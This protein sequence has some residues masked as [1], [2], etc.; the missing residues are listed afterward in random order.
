DLYRIGNITKEFLRNQ[1]FQLALKK[2][3]INKPDLAEKLGDYYVEKSPYKTRLFPHTIDTLEYLKKKYQLHIITNG[4]E[5]VQY[6]KMKHSGLD[7][8]FQQIVTSEQAGAK[9]PTKE[10]FEYSLNTAQAKAHES[11][12]IGDDLAVDIIGAQ[13]AGVDQVYFNYFNEEHHEK[14]TYEISSLDVLQDIL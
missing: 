5:E 6:I 11:I 10:I 12:M 4:F 2:F 1:R 14:P 7:K 8:Y 3:N 9:K 13:N